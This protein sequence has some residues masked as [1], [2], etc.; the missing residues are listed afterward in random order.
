MNEISILPQGAI[1]QNDLEVEE[2]FIQPTKTYKVDF[3]KGRVVGF[4]DG[5]EA[6]KQAICL[7]LNTERYEH[8]IYSDYYGSELKFLISNERNI[9]ES[10]YKRRIREALIQDDR[11]ESVDNFTFKYDKDGVLIEFM[12][13]SIYG[14]FDMER[15]IT[16]V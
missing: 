13:F 12:V 16:S 8:L 14:E 9:A 11:I 7:I 3:I 4:C 5:V 6:L 2:T 15:G 1:V 10:E